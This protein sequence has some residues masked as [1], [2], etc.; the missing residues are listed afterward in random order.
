MLESCLALIANGALTLESS[1][2]IRTTRRRAQRNGNGFGVSDRLDPISGGLKEFIHE[3][4]APRDQEF[5]QKAKTGI[6]GNLNEVVRDPWN[7]ENNAKSKDLGNFFG[8][9]AN[10][11]VQI[12]RHSNLPAWLKR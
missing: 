6:A 9:S 10:M 1:T 12:D 8:W 4:A 3:R 5:L 2:S 7:A 11:A